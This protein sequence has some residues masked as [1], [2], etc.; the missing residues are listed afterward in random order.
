MAHP[1][2]LRSLL[3]TCGLALAGAAAGA[4]SVTFELQP[5]ETRIA[6]T[7]GATMHTVHG[8][9]RARRGSVRFDPATGA[10]SGE[11]ALDAASAETGNASRDR[12]MHDKILESARY[13]EIVWRIDRVEGFP[14]GEARSARVTLAGNLAIHGASHPLTA[15]AEVAIGADRRT[16]A[17]AAFKIPYVAWGMKDPSSFVLR[18]D[19]EVAVEVQAVGRLQP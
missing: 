1:R 9:L 4:E 5:R 16:T 13:P 12:D 19:K 17:R 11:I 2:M 18:V 7:L 10:A 3:A 15:P 14:R 8:T 6:F